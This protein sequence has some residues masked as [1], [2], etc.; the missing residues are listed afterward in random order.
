M[1]R[2]QMNEGDLILCFVIPSNIYYIK[3]IQTSGPSLA[4]NRREVEEEG[5]PCM[6]YLGHDDSNSE[7]L[8]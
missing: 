5:A 7:L 1:T 2:A 8:I 4:I 3:H 6:W